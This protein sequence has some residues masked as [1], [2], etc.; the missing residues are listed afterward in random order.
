MNY[1]KFCSTI[2]PLALDEKPADKTRIQQHAVIDE[3]L[4]QALQ[5]QAG[6]KTDYEMILEKHKTV[7]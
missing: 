1:Q 7:N 5:K 3:D 6:Q 2:W 4:W